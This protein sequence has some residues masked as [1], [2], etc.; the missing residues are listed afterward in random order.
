MKS[1]DIG[2]LLKLLSLQKQEKA[3][4]RINID[5]HVRATWPDDW[6]DWDIELEGEQSTYTNGLAFNR[7]AESL[8]T[9][10]ALAQATGISKSQINTSLNRCIA[11]GLAKKDRKTG[12]PKANKKALFDFIVYGLKYVFPVAPGAL[13]RGIATAFS[14]PVLNKKIMSTGDFSLIWPDA[15]GSTKGMSVEPLFKA[16]TYAVR[17]DPEMY[18]LL[19]LIDS[20]R[21]GQP[22]EA[23]LAISLLRSHFELES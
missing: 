13:T 21:L 6:C 23:N 5:S 19:A 3:S 11:V 12:V 1:Q 20:I 7:Y 18:A 14:A 10:R 15:K 4:G 22:R 9:V 16:A 17:H 2:L 8:Y